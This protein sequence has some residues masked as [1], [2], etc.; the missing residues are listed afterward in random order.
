M[1]CVLSDVRPETDV[2][3]EHPTGDINAW[4]AQK[5]NASEVLWVCSLLTIALD[6][7]LLA[8]AVSGYTH[9]MKVL[10]V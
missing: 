4:F 2:T 8:I 7:N 6:W 9:Y 3:L 5:I 1:C 10:R